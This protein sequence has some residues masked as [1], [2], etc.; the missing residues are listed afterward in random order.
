MTSQPHLRRVE[1]INRVAKTLHRI[2]KDELLRNAGQLSYFQ[3]IAARLHGYPS[4]H[5]VTA[6]QFASP[7]VFDDDLAPDRLKHRRKSQI[8]VLRDSELIDP[9]FY[10][11]VLNALR[12]PSE[13]HRRI[14]AQASA[15]GDLKLRRVLD[16]LYS[17]MLGTPADVIADA[18]WDVIGT[19]VGKA[20]AT[21]TRGSGQGASKIVSLQFALPA[22][23]KRQVRPRM[24]STHLNCKLTIRRPSNSDRPV[25]S[26]LWIVIVSLQLQS[27]LRNYL[28][29]GRATQQAA[30]RCHPCRGAP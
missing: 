14:L 8:Q 1:R 29:A 12:S 28:G 23:I 2:C 10:D 16:N 15:E 3:E 22:P 30:P 21:A 11:W 20:R 27:P 6:E 4:F 9:D 5:V 13:G 19:D 7:F 18:A 26:G 24:R 17:L 25:S